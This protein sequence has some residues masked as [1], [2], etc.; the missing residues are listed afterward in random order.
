MVHLSSFLP[1]FL[2]VHKPRIDFDSDTLQIA[3]VLVVAAPLIWN[4]V[5]RSIRSALPES[6]NM[7]T[8]YLICYALTVWIFG[9]S[10]FRDYL[11]VEARKKTALCSICWKLEISLLTWGLPLCLFGSFHKVV[12]EQSQYSFFPSEPLRLVVCGVLFGLGQLFVLSSFYRLGVTGTFL[13]DYCGIFMSARVTGFPFS[14]LDN[15]MYVGSTMC[16]LAYSLWAGSYAGLLI[17]L[18]VAVVYA[19]ALQF[20]GPYTTKIYQERDAAARK[21]GKAQ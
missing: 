17:T 12:A 19:I 21:K 15:P 6:T 3:L 9:F 7:T 4:V 11:L 20:E 13:G 18:E 5:A 2:T 14:V 16:F 8:R 1:S 10:S